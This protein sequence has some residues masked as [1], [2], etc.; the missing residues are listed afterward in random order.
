VEHEEHV[1]AL[2]ADLALLLEAV[3][4]AGLDAAVPSCPGWTVRDL[5]DHLSEVYRHKSACI[6]LGVEPEPWP[7][8]RDLS[9]PVAELRAA[10]AEL[11]AELAGHAGS[12]PAATWHEPDQT[13]GFWSR[14]MAQ[15]TAVHRV[16]AELA[17][18]HAGAG[19][20][21]PVAADL[22]ADGVDE[23]LVVFAEGDWSDI[24]QPGPDLVV[25]LE[26][27]ERTWTVHL[28]PEA[29]RVEQ[30]ATVEPGVTVAG[31]ASDVLLWLWGRAERD[32]L[33]VAGDA[34]DADRLVQRLSHVTS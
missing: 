23:V 30:G 13:V 20:V 21:H 31:Q 4:R 11:L 32:R 33:T 12:D 29:L 24:P 28:L 8:E 1:T 17:A 5:V 14:R 3:D 25:R 9:D 19:S 7:P 26:V 34:A 27:P 2:Q 15:E 10:S 16:D 6:R 22:A 18:E